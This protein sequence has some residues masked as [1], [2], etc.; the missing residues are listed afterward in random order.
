VQSVDPTLPVF[1]AQTLTE[2]VSADLAQ[3]RFSMGIVALFALTA[4]LL[5]GLGIYGVIS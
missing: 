3:R 4:L 2:T 5:A 1:G